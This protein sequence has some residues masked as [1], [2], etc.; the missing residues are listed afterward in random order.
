MHDDSDLRCD[1]CCI[2]GDYG[3]IRKAYKKESQEH[4]ADI[5]RNLRR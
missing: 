5:K 1:G 4:M 3:H 2:C